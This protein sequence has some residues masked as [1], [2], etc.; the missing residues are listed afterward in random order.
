MAA[1]EGPVGDG[2]LW[3]TWL[4]NHVVFLRLRE[5]LKNQSPTEAEKPASSSF[6]SSPPP[7]LLTR[8]VVFGLGGELFL[9]DGED[10]SFLV[11]RLRGPGG[12]GEEPALSQ[13]QAGVQWRHL[14]SPQPPPS[15]FKRFF[16]LSPPE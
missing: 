5:G 11:V 13:Y 2:E 7:Q 9:W 10:S 8:N 6:P 16:C 12:G 15:S 4:P 1:A 14:G 3:Q